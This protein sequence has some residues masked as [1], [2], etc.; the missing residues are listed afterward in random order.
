MFEFPEKIW[1]N[2]KKMREVD[3]MI[4]RNFAKLGL[5]FKKKFRTDENLRISLDN[6]GR[7][8][9]LLKVGKT[10]RKKSGNSEY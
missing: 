5:V 3:E 10:T 1:E 8:K 6:A 9:N 4:K 2:G 7:R